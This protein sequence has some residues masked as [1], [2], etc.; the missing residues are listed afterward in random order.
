MRRITV[1]VS[2]FSLAGL[3]GSLSAQARAPM[4]RGGAP[5]GAPF[6]VPGAEML[7]SQTG[8][9]QLTD[10]QVVKLA[11]IARRSE[12]RRRALRT[13]LDSLRPRRVPGD[14][15]RRG[16]REGMLPTDLL[17]RERDAA[18]ADL[19][20]AL[21][22]LSPDQQASAWEMIAARR[23]MGFPGGAMPRDGGRPGGRSGAPLQRRPSEE[24]GG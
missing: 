8:A 4:G 22:V 18:H 7:L 9:L 20:D 24:E 6:G 12:D 23:P 2:T 13:R 19:R 1:L 5:G 15:T 16:L 3:T 21:A 17:T 10:A 14:T 11:A